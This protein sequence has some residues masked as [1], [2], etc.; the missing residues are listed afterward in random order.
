MKL[1][2]LYPVLWA[3]WLAAFLA[4]EFS[5]IGTGHHQY[6]LSDYVWRLEEINR[7]WTVLRYFVAAFCLWLAGHMIFGWFR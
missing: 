7:G 3:L 6:T 5:A 1:S 4:I 2:V